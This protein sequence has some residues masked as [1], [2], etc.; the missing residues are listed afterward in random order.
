MSDTSDTDGGEDTEVGTGPPGRVV[1]GSPGG[2]GG[3]EEVA[4][5]HPPGQEDQDLEVP[6]LPRPLPGA[7]SQKPPETPVVQPTVSPHLTQAVLL[8]DL[9][10][11]TV[12][13]YW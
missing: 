4:G 10:M 11:D 2:R 7:E 3:L 5:H 8:F 1:G 9:N 13:F 12:P 6:V